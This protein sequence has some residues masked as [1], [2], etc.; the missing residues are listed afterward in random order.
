M[1]ASGQRTVHR[2]PIVR[3]AV[4]SVFSAA[5]LSIAAAPTVAQD[6]GP[7]LKRGLY[8]DATLT[9]HVRSYFMD[10]TNASPPNSL[11]W[12]GGGWIGYETGW[13]YDAVRF[14]AVGYTSQ[15]LVA[16]PGM[17]GTLLLRP[18]QLGYTVLGQAWGKL[19][20]WDQEFTGYRQ[21][22]NQPEVNP[23]DSRMTPATFE[24]YTLAGA[25][26]DLSYFVGYVA[27]EKPRDSDRF[28]NMAQIAGAPAGVSEG[29]ALATLTYAPTDSF[30]T[31]LS[32]YHVPN[33][34]SSGYA[35]VSKSWSLSDNMD[36]KL[37]AQFM[38]QG[39]T[40][41]QL[42]TGNAF[43]TWAGGIDVDLTWGPVNLTATYTQTGRAAAY[44]TPYGTWAG[45][46]S[47]I[48]KDFDRANEGAALVGAKLD[49]AV[50]KMPG[51]A[52]TT[53]L[54][55]GNGAINATTGAALSTNNEYDFTLDYLVANSVLDWPDWARPLWLR[56][57]A[58]LVD[59]YQ[60]GAL[61]TIRDY[62]V[63]L[64]YEWKFGANGT[65]KKR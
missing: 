44:R 28:L 13:F 4:T 62:R 25:L 5:V 20:L 41:A 45:Y 60:N 40:G 1:T 48:V 31:R 38:V 42:L 59:Q 7:A 32:A 6:F 43:S 24:A 14:G 55:F 61:T 10:R 35:D 58:A 34:L 52:L 49:L 36:L 54:V 3:A 26:G 9:F 18:G 51:F 12:A 53:N 19:K 57:R 11:A 64:N 16:P 27:A 17:E 50:V 23:Q 30:K 47:M 56:G 8:D 33:I 15:P 2:R 65:T 29:M 46:T 21:L 22:I 39:S 63:I 37:A